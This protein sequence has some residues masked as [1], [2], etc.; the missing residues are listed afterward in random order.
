MS[1]N[2]REDDRDAIAKNAAALIEA[3]A[4]LAKLQAENEE[5]RKRAFL[6]RH[7]TRP[8]KLTQNKID[9][10]IAQ[11]RKDG[12]RHTFADGGNLQLLISV[13]YDWRK[14]PKGWP[15]VVSWL[16]KWAWTDTSVPKGKRG[17]YK[18]ECVGLGSERDLPLNAARE[19][20]AQ[21]RAW[22]DNGDNPKTEL[23]RLKYQASTRD[24]FRT[25]AQ[26]LDE[27]LEKKVKPEVRDPYTHRQVKQRFRDFVLPFIGAMPVESVT[28]KVIEEQVLRRNVDNRTTETDDIWTGKHVTASETR[29]HLEH[30]FHYGIQKK[31]RTGDNPARW[32]DE[33]TD[34]LKDVL[35]R[36]SKVHTVEHRPSLN[37]RKL[38]EFMQ[39]LRA[40]RYQYSTPLT[41]TDRP[42]VSYALEFLVLTGVRVSEVLKAEWNELHLDPEDRKWTVPGKHTK[43]GKP[44][45]LPITDSML[46]ILIEMQKL[47]HHPSRKERALVFPGTLRSGPTGNPIA[48]Q[49]LM[50]LVRTYLEVDLIEN[51]GW[52][53]TFKDWCNSRAA[54]FG[55]GYQFSWYQMQVDHWEGV[56]KSEQAYGPDRLLDERRLLMQAYDDFAITPPAERKADNVVPLKKRRTD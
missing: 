46:A 18:F 23:L 34:G 8:G 39:R 54:K 41:G 20:A 55:I 21:C 32:G 47:R 26:L 3:Q 40:F 14:G 45:S 25:V 9:K 17:R 16:F 10:A 4:L 51:H 38:P 19:K 2:D 27:Y 24:N 28:L 37:F 31:Y 29:R 53:S 36:P 44:R 50:R 12:K 6:R 33:K 15:V 52:R 7:Q 42:L 22:L 48:K 11:A 49:T 30:A 43:S 35:P 13:P 1:T 5:L 56:P